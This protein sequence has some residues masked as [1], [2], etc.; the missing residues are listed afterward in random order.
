MDTQVQ[1]ALARMAAQDAALAA[2]ERQVALHRLV[3]VELEGPR[4]QKGA[5]TL[6]V[7]LDAW[8]AVQAASFRQRARLAADVLA[9]RGYGHLPGAGEEE[10]RQRMKRIERRRKK[11][12][13]GSP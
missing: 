6:V 1:T 12:L 2:L 8:A 9:E 3:L 5:V 10:I 11:V 7:L 4:V 13:V